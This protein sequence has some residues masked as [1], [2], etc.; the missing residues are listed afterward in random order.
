MATVH[1]LRYGS[2]RSVA[3]PSWL[4]SRQEVMPFL[5]VG[6]FSAFSVLIVLT[7]VT[8]VRHQT[9]L[10]T[11]ELAQPMAVP[12]A[13]SAPEETEP[14]QASLLPTDAPNTP[15]SVGEQVVLHLN[16]AD[17]GRDMSVASTNNASPPAAP[18]LIDEP[19]APVAP[20]A[21]ATGVVEPPS[22]M[23]AEP[24]P[25]RSGPAPAPVVIEPP[26]APP[27]TPQFQSAAPASDASPPHNGSGTAA[28]RP[29]PRTTSSAPAPPAA[30]QTQASHQQPADPPRPV[31][32][33]GHRDPAPGPAKGHDE[34]DQ[35]EGAGRGKR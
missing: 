25:E 26:Q 5:M 3:A 14:P 21:D 9:R 35:G 31:R 34:H 15:G 19:E 12:S 10:G 20:Q 7:V 29:A 18:A 27:A 11:A 2:R 28:T 33:K 1:R 4:P 17:A 16:E 6:A 8:F 23:P 32:A 24:Q 13:S 30:P 22:P